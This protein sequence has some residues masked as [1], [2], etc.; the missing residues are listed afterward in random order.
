MDEAVKDAPLDQEV[1]KAE[2]D[3]AQAWWIAHERRHGCW[4]TQ[5]PIRLAITHAQIEIN[6]LI[7][8]GE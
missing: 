6:E 8:P 2:Y 4:G 1:A 5:C 3:H 7:N